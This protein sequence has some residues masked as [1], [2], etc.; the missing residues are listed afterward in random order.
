MGI[1]SIS[2][3]VLALVLSTSVNAE[4]VSLS[5]EGGWL[6]FSYGG[7]DSHWND[8]FEFTI[9]EA[10]T[11]KVTPEG[12]SLGDIF[13]VFAGGTSLGITSSSRSLDTFSTG[14]WVFQAGTYEITG[15]VLSSTNSAGTGII[16]LDSGVPAVPIPAAVWLFGTGLIGLIGLARRKTNA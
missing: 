1:K 10:S 9:T 14:L 8:S 7:N 15:V 16:R 3:A 4:L 2:L 11:L 6:P 13:E 12:S 5:P